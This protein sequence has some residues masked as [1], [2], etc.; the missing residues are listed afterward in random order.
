MMHEI[1][2]MRGSLT[3]WL[4]D[5]GGNRRGELRRH[6]RIVTSGR[7][8]V[9]QLFGG[10][11]AGPPPAKVTHMAVGTGTKDPDDGQTGLTAEVA[12]NAITEVTYTPFADGTGAG[13][14]Q[15][16]RVSLKSIFD[17][18]DANGAALTE[19]G[20]FTAPAAGVM[21]NRVT[22]LP[23]NKTKEFQLTLLWDVVF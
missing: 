12:R 19:A 21:Y 11:T 6:N 9:A 7:L 13:A 10:I 5:A 20:I 17:F 23:V 18:P 14:A 8:L 4:T 2:E 22:F 16:V 15:R 3:L 1:N